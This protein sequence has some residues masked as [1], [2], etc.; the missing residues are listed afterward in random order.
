[1][2]N[3]N[4]YFG[5]VQFAFVDVPEELAELELGNELPIQIVELE[6]VVIIECEENGGRD[7]DEFEVGDLL[8]EVPTLFELVAC[9]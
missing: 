1:M 7:F 9:I 6:I 2:F 5:N 4:L 8:A 3:L